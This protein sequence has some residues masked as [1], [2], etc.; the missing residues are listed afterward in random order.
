MFA[1]SD[2][3]GLITINTSG[4]VNGWDGIYALSDGAAGRI[5]I[6]STAAVTGTNQYGIYGH[7]NGGAILIDARAQV[8]GGIGGVVGTVAGNGA[9]DIR[10]AGVTASNGPAV[11]AQSSGGAI[12]ITGTGRIQSQS[13]HRHQRHH[14]L[15]RGERSTRRR[16]AR[17][18]RALR[19]ASRR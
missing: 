6:L 12:T 3:N 14:H 8:S 18:L 19:S 7:T 13:A 17:S 11:L 4:T 9:V 15:G 5:N 1:E 2:T 16:P 10:T